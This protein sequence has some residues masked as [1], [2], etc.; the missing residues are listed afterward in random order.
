[1]R[2]RQGWAAP[3]GRAGSYQVT[4]SAGYGDPER[5]ADRFKAST[6]CGSRY[7]GRAAPEVA[8]GEADGGSPAAEG[9]LLPGHEASKARRGGPGAAGSSVQ[10]QHGC[11]SRYEGRAVPGAAGQ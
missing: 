4:S 2:T 5:S 3:G 10:G 6:G 8:A 11:G 7:E 9:R 1:M